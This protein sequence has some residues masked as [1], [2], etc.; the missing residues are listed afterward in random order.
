MAR[1]F[2]RV[3]RELQEKVLISVMYVRPVLTLNS[4]L[5]LKLRLKMFL[6]GG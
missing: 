4:R 5:M 2:K 3:Q 1:E 6:T